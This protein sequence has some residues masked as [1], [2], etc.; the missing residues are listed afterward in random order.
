MKFLIKAAGVSALAAVLAI[1]LAN[2][3]SAGKRHRHHPGHG[4][5]H[6]GYAAAASLGLGMF[7]LMLNRPRVVHH[8]HKRWLPARVYH[9]PPTVYVVPQV[10]Y[11]IRPTPSPMATPVRQRE[12]LSPGCLMVREYQTRIIIGGKEVEAYGDAC[13]Q[14]DGSWRR[15]PPKLVPH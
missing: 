12:T 13:M 2:P 5:H 9:Q 4:H 1:G 6:H 3:S 8:R 11:V 14:P 15:G 7:S 10:R